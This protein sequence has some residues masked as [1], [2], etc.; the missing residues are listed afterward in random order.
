MAVRAETLEMRLPRADDVSEKV[1]MLLPESK[2]LEASEDLADEECVL[3]VR[4]EAPS[5]P[6]MTRKESC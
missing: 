3:V 1:R 6:R 5:L 2:T 4:I